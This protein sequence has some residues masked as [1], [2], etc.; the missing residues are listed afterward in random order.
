[1]SVL[2]SSGDAV[3][4]TG[5]TCLVD[6]TASGVS[7]DTRTVE[8]GDLF[9]ALK[10][11]RDGHDFV[12]EALKKG[13]AAAM[14]S[15]VPDGVAAD[16]SLLIVGDVLL[17]LEDLGKA[18]RTR[19]RAKVIGV[20]GSVGKTGTKEMLRT[21]LAPQG[22]VHA[23]ER[24]FNN[25]WGVPLTLARMPMDTDFAVIEIGM[26]H[27]G[28]IGPL[29]RMADL[30]VAVVTTVAA[31]HMA[32]FRNVEEIARAK[33]EIFEGLRPGGAAVLNADISTRQVLFDAADRAGAKTIAFGAHS[34]APVRMISA[35]IGGETTTVEALFEDQPILFKLGAPGRHL[36]MNALAALAASTAAGADLARA[37]LAL[38]HWHAPDGRGARYLVD[39]ANGNGETLELIDESYNANPTSM[40][41]AL[42]VLAS[43]RPVDNVGRIVKGRRIAFLGD[44]LELGPEELDL[45]ASLAKVAELGDIDK[46]HTSGTRM[47]ALHRA[48]PLQKQGEWFENADRM[49][50][51][52]HTLLDAG[53]VVM[54]KGSLGS[55][56][57]QVVKAIKALGE[58]AAK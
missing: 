43:A 44:M 9:V 50:K 16:A 47:R 28:E 34:A 32:A 24:S 20:T 57:G 27:P 23:A 45:H 31:V 39:L 13:A 6:W 11:Q 25:H 41:A 48:L 46:V 22:R 7:I 33:A 49:A 40:E 52:I 35:V 58:T 37:M 14:V 29:A 3:A 53:D 26:N 1:M 56:V 38:Q 36:A 18:A 19:T 51:N 8:P 54:V 21:A 15:R 17:A 4:A 2:W 5:G 55:H 42:A 10:D 12:A 30:D